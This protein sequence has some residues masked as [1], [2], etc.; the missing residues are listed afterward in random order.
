[1]A[2]SFKLEK[3]TPTFPEWVIPWPERSSFLLELVREY[4]LER[5]VLRKREKGGLEEGRRR[6]VSYLP[7]FAANLRRD[8]HGIF[9]RVRIDERELYIRKYTDSVSSRLIQVE[10]EEGLTADHGRCLVAPIERIEIERFAD[11]RSLLVLEIRDDRVATAE[12]QT[13]NERTRQLFD[14]RRQASLDN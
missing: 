8:S 11:R 12:K 2:P 5:E 10:P 13:R 6:G 14:L 9:G 1:L 7:F 4:K 3:R